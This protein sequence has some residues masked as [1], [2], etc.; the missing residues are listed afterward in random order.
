MGRIEKTVFISYRRNNV[1]WALAIFQEL[2]SH[3]YDVFFDYKSIKSGDFEQVILGNIKARAHFLVILTPSALERC[4]EPSDWLRREIET[5]IEERRNI[6]PL[7]LEGFDFGA[8]ST[9]KALTGK[10]SLLKRYNGLSVPA[11]Y[12]F[13]AMERLRENYLNVALS[14]IYLYPLSGEAREVSEIQIKAASD[15]VP[16]EQEQLTAQEWAERGFVFYEA[17]N[18]AEAIRCYSE[19]IRIKP[20][21]ATAYFSRGFSRQAINDFDSAIADFSEAIRLVPNF[22]DF[23]LIRGLAR[24]AD[25]DVKGAIADFDKVIGLEPHYAPSYL[26]RGNAFQAIGDL[27]NAYMDYKEMIRL[28]PDDVQARSSLI[29]VLLKMERK[30]EAHEQEISTRELVAKE[31]EYNRACFE[32]ICGNVDK[33][34]ELLKIGLGKK[35]T[36]KEWARRNPDFENIRDDPRFRVLVDE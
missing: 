30:A 2:T 24:N 26:E 4:N 8:S 12:F 10:L 28:S 9:V 18:R 21:Y 31:N 11:E 23:Y 25:N 13:E 17:N 16:V 22:S 1:P 20:D 36:T 27:E 35:Q 32:A 33:A 19:A 15:A 34:L 7:I 5:A 29:S 3:G 14:D 6:V